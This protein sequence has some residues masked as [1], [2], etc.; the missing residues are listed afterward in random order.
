MFSFDPVGSYEREF[1]RAAGTASSLLQPLLDNQLGFKNQENVPFRHMPKVGGCSVFRR[2]ADQVC[3]FVSSHPPFSSSAHLRQDE[4]VRL[5]KD[6]FSS[7]AERDIYTG[8]AVHI[9]I[10]TKEGVEH[11]QHPLRRYAMLLRGAG[12][13]AAAVCFPAP[14]RQPAPLYISFQGLNRPR[15]GVGAS[16]RARRAGGARADS[17]FSR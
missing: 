12:R 9:A 17:L 6:V 13:H 14:R 15:G 7:A 16:R 3:P 11:Q 2:R 5:V 10:I 1:F 8:D 4:A